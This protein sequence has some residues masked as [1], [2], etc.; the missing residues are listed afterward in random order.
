MSE[1]SSAYECTECNKEISYYQEWKCAT[2][3]SYF[4]ETCY[5]NKCV[6]YDCMEAGG[7]RQCINCISSGKERRY[8]LEEDCSCENQLR[9]NGENANNKEKRK[10]R[11]ASLKQ[12]YAKGFGI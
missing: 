7:K 12:A 4:D 9:V 1:E 8:C 10:S 11:Y 2:C 6:P 5:I 3:N